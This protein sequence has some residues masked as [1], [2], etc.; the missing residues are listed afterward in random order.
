MDSWIIQC[1]T[2]L[3][4]DSRHQLL[5]PDWW[6]DKVWLRFGLDV[7]LHQ[8]ALSMAVWVYSVSWLVGSHDLCWYW[9][10][11]KP[12]NNLRQAVGAIR[13]A[14][15]TVIMAAVW[16][17]TSRSNRSHQ[18]W[19]SVHVV[20]AFA[21]RRCWARTRPRGWTVLLSKA[22]A[23]WRAWA[24]AR[25]ACV[26]VLEARTQLSG[27]SV[28]TTWWHAGWRK[29]WISLRVPRGWGVAA[30]WA[31][32]L[33]F[34]VDGA[35]Q[36][37]HSEC[38]PG[39]GIHQCVMEWVLPMAVMLAWWSDLDPGTHSLG[40]RPYVLYVM[41]R[42]QMLIARQSLGAAFSVGRRLLQRVRVCV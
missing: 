10:L 5:G 20:G 14:R 4:A 34:T 7:L 39:A 26:D 19:V 3:P 36:A 27:H 32:A 29:G 33:R 13:G 38:R 11:A 16:R 40:T 35:V 23:G 37:R 42:L 2:N 30:G 18:I 15:M 25:G 28:P 6:N 12:I 41:F 22:G 31:Q 24:G 8:V 21:L 9:P 17:R 1:W